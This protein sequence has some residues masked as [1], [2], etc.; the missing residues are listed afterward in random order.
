MA[1]KGSSKVLKG[2]AMGMAEVVPGV[3]GGTIAFITGIYAELINTIKSFTPTNLKL[4]FQGKLKDFAQ[5]VNLNFLIPLII[6]M[7]IGIVC[8]VFGISYL[9]ENHPLGVW[10]F[11]FG[12][13]VASCIYVAKQI[14]S[15]NLLNVTLLVLFAVLGYTVT[16]VKPFEAIDSTIWVFVCGVIAVSALLLPGLSGSF[17]LLLLNMY[18]PIFGSIKAVLSTQDPKAMLTTGIFILGCITG[19]LSFS[20]V[21][22]WAFKK[23]EGA[24]LAALAGL[25]LGSL[26]KVWPWQKVLATRINSEGHE[27]ITFTKSVSPT[28]FSGL[29]NNFLY[30]N[31]PNYLLVGV[32]FIVGIALVLGLDKIS[33]HEK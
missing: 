24:T 29:Q 30:G 19:L 9:L 7:F 26:N 2:F 17:I 11:F 5:A 12:L 13:I 10:S 33:T 3:S 4:L 21:L 25:L 16:V 31:N 27:L 23:Y 32:C 22:S 1:L 8:G 28:A 20:R 18:Q 6:G 15:W 14:K